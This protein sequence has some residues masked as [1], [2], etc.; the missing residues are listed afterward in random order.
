MIK[1]STL[2]TIPERNK[3]K[4][5]PIQ[6]LKDSLPTA[7]MEQYKDKEQT[8][9]KDNNKKATKNPPSIVILEN[10]KSKVQ[11]KLKLKDPLSALDRNTVK[12]EYLHVKILFSDG[13]ALW[14]IET[15]I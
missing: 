15:E 14:M 11:P 8:K 13:E 3:N 2:A 7:L 5:G 9:D 10:N 1:D 12:E 4:D 6:Q